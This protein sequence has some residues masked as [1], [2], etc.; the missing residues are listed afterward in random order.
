MS[1]FNMKEKALM[2]QYMLTT[3]M[4]NLALE[5]AL[6]GSDLVEDQCRSLKNG[7]DLILRIIEGSTLLE[8][9][10]FKEGLAPSMEGV[11]VYG[12]ALSSIRILNKDKEIKGFTEYF[13]NIRNDIEKLI[14]QKKKDNIDILLLKD[15]FLALGNS[16]RGDIQKESYLR[17]QAYIREGRAR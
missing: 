2:L 16:F 5:D 3:D 10:D 6:E 4:V 11:S 1:L 17:N 9:K 13:E 8:G 15:F 12:Y 7:S 14:A